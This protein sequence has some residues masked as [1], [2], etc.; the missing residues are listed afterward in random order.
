MLTLTMMV[1][2][3]QDFSWMWRGVSVSC[4]VACCCWACSSGELTFLPE[5]VG[6]HALRLFAD[7]STPEET[8]KH[9]VYNR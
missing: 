7:Q 3:L 1:Q 5:H 9:K 8:P 6:Q 4:E 2:H